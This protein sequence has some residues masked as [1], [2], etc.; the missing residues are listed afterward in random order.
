MLGVKS[1]YRTYELRLIE[2]TSHHETTRHF[3]C[4]VVVAGNGV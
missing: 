4:E 2:N 3:G 1:N